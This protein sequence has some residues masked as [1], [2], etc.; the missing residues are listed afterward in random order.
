[1]A[2]RTTGLKGIAY[3]LGISVNTVSRALRD[4]DDIS[5]ATKE[6]VRQKAYELGYLP[7]NI[8]QFI[9]RNG[10]RLIAIVINSFNNFYF[11]IMCSKFVPLILENNCDFTVIVSL[12]KKFGEDGVKQCISQ[13]VDAI[14]TLLEP[15]DK[16]IEVTKLNNIPMTLI[17]RNIDKD[18][19]DQ[20]YTDDEEGGKLVAKYFV[21]AHHLNKFIYIKM[22]NIECSR[23]RGKSFISVLSEYFP[24]PD[25]LTIDDKQA[26]K[27]LHSLVKK[28]YNGVFCFNDELAYELLRELN[29]EVPNYRTIYPHFHIAGYDAL[30]TQVKGLIDLTSVASNYDEVAKVAFNLTMNRLDNPSASPQKVMFPVELHIRKFI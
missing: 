2:N 11:D 1:M 7:N 13:R 24:K 18:Y 4:C 29:F 26:R 25:V 12:T 27:S 6:K 30:S 22:P 21:E 19:I 23:R 9:K 20:V 10:K 14:I 17:G 8:S 28:G 15:D 16:A 5:E 3:E